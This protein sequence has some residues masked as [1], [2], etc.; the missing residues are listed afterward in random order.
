MLSK[1]LITTT[2]LEI[3][4]AIILIILLVSIRTKSL[5]YFYE[6]QSYTE[7][8][9]NIEDSLAAQNLTTYDQERVSSTIKD[10]NSV[11]NKMLILLLV[12]LPLS[13]FLL[14]L[15]FYFIIWRIISNISIKRFLG[16]IIIPLI[17]FLL[18]IYFALNYLAY[19]YGYIGS[20]S[21]IQLVFSLIFLILTY[22]I[23]L[24]GLSNKK[25]LKKNL[26][27]PFKTKKTIPYYI[28]ML[29]LNIIF[30]ILVFYVFFLTFVQAP[31]IIPSIILLISIII[32][33]IIRIKFSEKLSKL[34]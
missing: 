26:I 19:Y 1:K 28:L 11:L 20:S 21:L 22:Y 15:I 32:S 5:N 6:V 14:S 24:F 10:F 3:L 25:S 31:I 18:T 30:V 17:L 4:F 23:S 33:N 12:I 16:Y 27:L 13:V 7:E 34:T 2:V 9:S 8:V 29:I